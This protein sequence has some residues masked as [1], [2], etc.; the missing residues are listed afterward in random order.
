MQ[1]VVLHVARRRVEALPTRSSLLMSKSEWKAMERLEMLVGC[2]LG[3]DNTVTFD[4]LQVCSAGR[5]LSV[6]CPRNSSRFRARS[7]SHHT[8]GIH[9]GSDPMLACY[10]D[11]WRTPPGTILRQTHLHCLLVNHRQH[12][13]YSSSYPYLMYAQYSASTP[14]IN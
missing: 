1:Q 13:T 9:A 6:L 5:T 10:E 11:L 14:D 12:I 3:V 2:G 7:N 8:P 4:L